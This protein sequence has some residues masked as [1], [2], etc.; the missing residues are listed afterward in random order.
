VEKPDAAD[1]KGHLDEFGV[2]DVG[3]SV[4]SRV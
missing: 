2:H 3:F 1:D 4:F